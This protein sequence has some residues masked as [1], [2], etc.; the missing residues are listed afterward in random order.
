MIKLTI[1]FESRSRCD[2][3]KC[4]AWRYSEDESTKV[5][6]LVVKVEGVGPKDDG[7]HVWWPKEIAEPTDHFELGWISQSKMQAYISIADTIEAH[8]AGFERAIWQ[9]VMVKKYGWAA[10]PDHR[11]RC[12]MAKASFWTLPRSLGAAAKVMNTDTQKDTTG[13][14]I[15]L[16]WCKP[17]NPTKDNKKE[18]ADDPDEFDLLVKYCIDDVKAEHSLSSMLPD[19]D[20]YELKVWQL[21]ENMNA[22]GVPIDMDLVH[23]MKKLLALQDEVLLVELH[24]IT[25]GAINTVG[26]VKKGVVWLQEQGF[27]IENLQKTT[28]EAALNP[29]S[30]QALTMPDHVQRYLE[31]RQLLAS[32]A[33]KKLDKMIDM[34]CADGRIRGCTT[35]CGA[36]RTSR[37]SGAM[38]QLQNLMRPVIKDVE[39]CVQFM[40]K[41][42]DDPDFM[43]IFEMFWPH[44]RKAVG[45][46]IRPCIA[47]APGRV[48]VCADYSAI[49][50]RILAWLAGETTILDAYVQGL[51]MYKINA[52]TMYGVAYDD[53]TYDQRQA[54]KVA[55]LAFGYQGATGA[56]AKFAADYKVDIPENE[57]LDFVQDWRKSR[58]QTVSFWWDCQDAAIEAIKNPGKTVYCRMLRFGVRKGWL[59]I[60]LPSGRTLK[61]AAINIETEAME[62]TPKPAITA[63]AKESGVSRDEA[64]QMIWEAIEKAEDEEVPIMVGEFVTVIREGRWLIVH[65]ED[66]RTEKHRDITIQSDGRV[67]KLETNITYYGVNS[68]RGNK[69][70]KMTTYGGKLVENVTQA[71]ARDIMAQGFLNAEEDGF[72]SIMTVHD[73]LDAECDEK[74]ADLNAFIEHLTRLPD[75][76]EGLPMAA[77]GWIGKRYR[78]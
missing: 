12:S 47:T 23:A 21:T 9:N 17:R 20:A 16:K 56:F 51:D 15:M 50:G 78:K 45:S 7:I 1:D 30:I 2:L 25:G 39:A 65:A 29:D 36:S 37:W 63:V 46:C 77:A 41:H 67:T 49:E 64:R 76:A 69:W 18:W 31:I 70:M 59:H 26:Q 22:R 60:R 38:L 10:V 35:Y 75:W 42:H 13:R 52:V 73:E 54:G 6:C 14:L 5:M 48:Q 72:K 24:E 3:R 53:V 44:I 27:E 43:N 74:A 11:W 34:V 28:V 40:L 61:Y 19:L 55:E 71:V 4:G 57:V 58:P 62:I 66:K 68:E 8:G 33:C 32:A